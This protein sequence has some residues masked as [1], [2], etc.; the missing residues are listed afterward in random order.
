MTSTGMPASSSACRTPRWARPRE[1]PPDRTSPT[2][3]PAIHRAR[4]PMSCAEEQKS[5][6]VCTA[7]K[8]T[9]GCDA[10]CSE[11]STCASSSGSSWQTAENFVIKVAWSWLPHDTTH[12]RQSHFRS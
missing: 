11:Q 12:D 2:A 9:I 6:V 1:P 8:V 7:H 10:T 4:R 3:R 5:V